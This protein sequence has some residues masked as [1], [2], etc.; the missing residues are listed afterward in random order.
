MRFKWSLMIVDD[1]PIIRKGLMSFEWEKLGF[2][3]LY[4]ASNGK[5]AIKILNENNVDVILTD[6]KMP[7]M[8]GLALCGYVSEHFPE[9][10][11][12]ILT[13]YNLY[14]FEN[15]KKQFKAIHQEIEIYLKRIEENAR[16]ESLLT[17]PFDKK[18]DIIKL[19]NRVKIWNFTDCITI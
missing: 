2:Q 8:D 6:I 12:V 7:V 4:S 19:H 16:I 1:E 11:M 15:F 18:G 9:C 17:S 13:G 14:S 10:K 3:A 5:E